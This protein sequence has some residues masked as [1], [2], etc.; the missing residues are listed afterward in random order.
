MSHHRGKLKQVIEPN[1]FNHGVTT[2]THDSMHI[3]NSF[4]QPGSSESSVI[5]MIMTL[6]S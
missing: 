3:S 1:I 4:A 2:H 5:G 6:K